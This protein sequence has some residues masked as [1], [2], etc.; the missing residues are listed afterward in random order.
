MTY[1]HVMNRG[2]LGVKSPR[3][4]LWVN[5]RGLRAYPIREAG[6]IPARIAFD[7]EGYD[8]KRRYHERAGYARPRGPL[9]VRPAAELE[10]TSRS[11]KV[12]SEMIIC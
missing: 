1:L 7:S 4:R 10:T 8:G 3:D 5:T 6:R 12:C 11:P 2:A 9:I